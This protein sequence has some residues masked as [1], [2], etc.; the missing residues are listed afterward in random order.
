LAP[1]NEWIKAPI[2]A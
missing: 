2:H 1:K